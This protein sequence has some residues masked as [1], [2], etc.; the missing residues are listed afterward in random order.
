MAP[1]SVA[2]RPRG[3]AV[4][5][6]TVVMY[7]SRISCGSAARSGTSA[8]GAVPTPVSGSVSSQAYASN[9]IA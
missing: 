2:H 9:A 6:L 1:A 7:F 3:S 8:S 5:R 4:Q